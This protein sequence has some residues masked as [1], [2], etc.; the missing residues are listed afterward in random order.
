MTQFS[1]GYTPTEITGSVSVLADDHSPV[2]ELSLAISA[3]PGNHPSQVVDAVSAGLQAMK[4]SLEAAFPGIT[5]SVS[6]PVVK[7]TKQ[8]R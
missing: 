5:A 4:S 2:I 7:G 6:G 3:L 1:D 8:L